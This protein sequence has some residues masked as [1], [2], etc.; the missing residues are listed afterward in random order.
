MKRCSR[1]YFLHL[2]KSKMLNVLD[3]LDIKVWGKHRIKNHYDRATIG[4]NMKA[5]YIHI[6]VLIIITSSPRTQRLLEAK[7]LKIYISIGVSSC[8]NFQSLISVCT[9][10]EVTR[11]YP[12]NSETCSTIPHL[13]LPLC[14]VAVNDQP[15]DEAIIDR[16]WAC[17]PWNIKY[18]A[19]S[20]G[21]L[22]TALTPLCFRVQPGN[23]R[24]H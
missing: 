22:H 17:A 13:L 10:C 23:E 15:A 7:H 20:Q 5:E 4:L 14:A 8:S 6:F 2:R 24:S 12:E 3:K 16:N 18:I 9:F 11:K 1:L 21:T 19:S